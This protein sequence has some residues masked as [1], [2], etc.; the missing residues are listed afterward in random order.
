[1]EVY[2]WGGHCDANIQITIYRHCVKL[3]LKSSIIN[4]VNLGRELRGGASNYSACIV[5]LYLL[6][7]C[8]YS[9]CILDFSITTRNVPG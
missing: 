9:I 8:N 6:F 2:V 7:R 4:G 1:M 5:I 3:V